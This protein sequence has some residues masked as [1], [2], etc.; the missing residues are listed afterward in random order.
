MVPMTDLHPADFY[1]TDLDDLRR[2][3]LRET[4]YGDMPGDLAEVL[5]EWL[6]DEH[7][8]IS[9]HHRVGSFLDR[10]AA[11][12]YRVTKIEA[13][14]F[15]EVLPLKVGAVVGFHVEKCTCLTAEGMVVHSDPRCAG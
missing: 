4:E 12:G 5:D 10:L 1:E 13:P 7:G 3:E 8:V 14:S 2:A 11:A 6:H 15:E 9:S